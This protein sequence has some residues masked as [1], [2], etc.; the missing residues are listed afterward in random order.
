MLA[1]T[2]NSGA[3]LKGN[4]V[5]GSLDPYVTFHVGDVRNPELGRTLAHENTSNPKWDE[6][7]FLLINNLNDMLCLQLMD[8]N[9]G[10]K[11]S[12][13]GVAVFELKELTESNNIVE[14]L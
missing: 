14:G 7:H 11:D 13:V 8:R 4:D 9:T 5:F 3:N 2:I 6:T 1:L 12:D 10:R